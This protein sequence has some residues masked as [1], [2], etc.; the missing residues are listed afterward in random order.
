MYKR[1]VIVHTWT[2]GSGD[3]VHGTGTLTDRS[4]RGVGV[5][6]GYGMVK[7]RGAMR[8]PEKGEVEIYTT[9]IKCTR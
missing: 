5:P 6:H 4:V 9:Y 7:A 2:F 3:S 8:Y 1:Q